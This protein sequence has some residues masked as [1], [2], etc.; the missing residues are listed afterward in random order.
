[1]WCGGGWRAWVPVI[2]LDQAAPQV[3]PEARLSADA[4]V[5]SYRHEPHREIH[6]RLPTPR[7]DNRRGILERV[8]RVQGALGY[9]LQDPAPVPRHRAALRPRAL[10]A[11]R[12]HQAAGAAFVKGGLRRGVFHLWRSRGP[13]RFWAIAL[14]RQTDRR[15]EVRGATQDQ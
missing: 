13:L 4:A 1:M 7:P 12:L 9:A 15:S 6:P 14:A 2:R 11:D 10:R 5:S 3:Y 8:Q